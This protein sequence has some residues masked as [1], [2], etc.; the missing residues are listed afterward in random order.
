MAL[1][2]EPHL[3]L[4]SPDRLPR[5]ALLLALLLLRQELAPPRTDRLPLAMPHLEVLL[6]DST[7]NS[8][9]D[10]TVNNSLASTV[11][12]NPV[13]TASSKA[14][15]SRPSNS[16]TALLLRDILHL[17]SRRAAETMTSATS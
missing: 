1:Q 16:S 9:L 15:G 4:D 10:S 3:V 2:E 8:N 5:M 14:T 12:S 6:P 11:T 13:N 7:A 17:S